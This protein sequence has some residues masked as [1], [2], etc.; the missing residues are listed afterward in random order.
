MTFLD[1]NSN[2][3]VRLVTRHARPGL[4]P[5]DVEDA[6]RDATG[7]HGRAGDHDPTAQCWCRVSVNDIERHQLKVQRI[8]LAAPDRPWR[9]SRRWTSY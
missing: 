5:W 8:E 2:G 6:F 7:A 9:L 3:L 4:S 1:G